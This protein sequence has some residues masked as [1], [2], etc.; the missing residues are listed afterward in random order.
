M[1]YLASSGGLSCPES[2]M[3]M[4]YY[5]MGGI[6]HIVW[7]GVVHQVGS[8]GGDVDGENFRDIIDDRLTLDASLAVS[9]MSY[10]FV[11][12]APYITIKIEVFEDLPYNA[13]TYLRVGICENGLSYGG[14]DYHNILRDMP[15]DTPLSIM[16]VGEIQEV[17]LPLAISGQW[18][19]AELWA[20]AFVQRDS[21]KLKAI[22]LVSRLSM[23]INKPDAKLAGD[24]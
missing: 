15:Q 20:F 1:E 14:D 5:N 13:N 17:T 11:G 3:R 8:G 16:N 2:D 7:D 6:P 4:N 21:D 18:D 12:D 24:V 10:S 9:V 19:P 22:E 23:K